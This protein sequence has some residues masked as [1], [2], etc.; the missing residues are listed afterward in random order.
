MTINKRR[1]IPQEKEVFNIQEKEKREE[2]E[3]KLLHDEQEKN[4]NEELEKLK[5]CKNGKAGRIWE[6]RKKVVGGKDKHIVSKAI[7]NPIN[8]KMTVNRK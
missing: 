2:V 7:I 5:A 6:I 8:G 1:P 4:V 3:A